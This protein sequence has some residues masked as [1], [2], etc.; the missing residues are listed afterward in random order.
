M[1]VDISI[2]R[3]R[4]LPAAQAARRGDKV[5]MRFE[6]AT[7]TYG[8]F[9]T[10]CNRVANALIAAG[11]EPQS[12]V[13]WVSKNTDTFYEMLFGAAKANCVLVPVNW[14][15]APAEIS[16]IVNDAQARMLMVGADFAELAAAALGD[17]PT[18]ETGIAVDGDHAEWQ[19]YTGWRD[20]QGDT[21]PNVPHAPDDTA[22]QMY[23]SG[24]TGH[25]KGAE[26]S[27][28]NLM[29]SANAATADIGDWSPADVSQ[30]VMPQ[31]HIAGTVWGLVG[32]YAG[33]E[34]V[35]MR[36]VDPPAILQS[37]QNDRI[38]KSFMVPAVILFLLQQPTCQNT[39][40]SSL[41]LLV[42]GASPIPM[43]LLR[44]AMAAFG[45]G[46]GQVYGLTET[47]GAVTYLGPEHHTAEGSE[48]MKSCGAA[49]SGV[50]MAILDPYGKFM[51]P[52]EIGEI[53]C[54]TALNMKGYYNKP[55]ATK[56]AIRDG[57]FHSGD[58]GYMDADGY[59]Y[60][61]DR[62]K[63]MIISGGENIYPAE[64][65]SAL[66]GHPAVAD[67]AVIGVPD[68][69]WGE[70]VKA[71]VVKAPDADVS[72]DDLINFTRERIAHY[73]APKTVDFIDALPRNP[74]GKILKRTLREPYWEGHEKQVV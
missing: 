47:T 64:V 15:L 7:T 18:V 21:D 4:D 53:A 56:N 1:A 26:L 62:V 35:V 10:R 54:R 24:T 3:I 20:A 28:R 14:R 55:D 13:A 45:C 59:V 65:E 68:E 12:R 31:F 70:Q 67:V 61:Y 5:A 42:Y 44:N 22:M 52:G 16:Y 23:T 25:P 66:F 40:F 63:D 17:L 2:D 9:E 30:V 46:F 60:I 57:W 69:T 58:A 37:I 73:K 33:A 74:S 11:L 38:T 41:E 39:D 6:G 49:M 51:P 29:A 8:E 71:I 72:A 50:E 19:A 32:L 48:R 27:H 43:D 36:D 34:G